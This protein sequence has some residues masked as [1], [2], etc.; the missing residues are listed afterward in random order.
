MKAS[1]WPYFDARF[2]ALAHRGG[3]LLPQNVGHEN[4]MVAFHNAVD[5]GYRY[6][7]TDVHVTSDGHLVA[8]HDST[9]D[10]V[11][12]RTGRIAELTLDQVREASI[13]TEQVPTLQELLEAFPQVN[14]NIDIKASGAEKP[15]ASLLRH[16]AAEKRVCVGSFS[17]TRLHRFR[18]ASGGRVAT[19]CGPVGVSA[20]VL[21]ARLGHGPAPIGAAFQVPIRHE[22]AGRTVQVVTPEFIRR[23]HA[24]GKQVHVWTIDDPHQMDELIDWGVDGLVSDRPDLLK[25]V[26]QRR[27]MWD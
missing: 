24:W 3:A 16:H 4:T 7:E 14:I 2:I 17:Q 10:R 9:L 6:L 18:L 23:A 13:G 20:G 19:S 12:D 26:L 11:T 25:E 22:L 1:R 8:F 21:A 27:G 15:L 5:L